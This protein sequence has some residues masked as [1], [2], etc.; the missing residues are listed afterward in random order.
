MRLCS[1]FLWEAQKRLCL[2]CSETVA[3][4]KSG[5]VKHH[6]KTKLKITFDKS[7]PPNPAYLFHLFVHL[8]EALK[9]PELHWK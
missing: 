9:G 5:N 3:V 7:Y 2:I 8:Y 4:V 1:S 6:Y